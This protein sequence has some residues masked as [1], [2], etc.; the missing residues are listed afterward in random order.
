MKLMRYRSKGKSGP[1]K[2]GLVLGERVLEV[3]RALGQV[4]RADLAASLHEAGGDLEAFI[5]LE[6]G[7]CPL[8]DFAAAYLEGQRRVGDDVLEQLSGV[9]IGPPLLHPEKIIGIGL[10]Y[11]SHA[12]ETGAEIPKQPIFFAKYPN[13][14]NAT[15]RPVVKSA[16]TDKLDYEV[17]LAVVIGKKG[18]W[19]PEESALDYVFG[20]MAANDV[21]ARDLQVEDGQWTKGKTLDT[22]FPIGPVLVTKNDIPDPQNLSLKLTLNG[23]VMQSGNTSDMIFSVKRLVSYLS[24]LMTLSPGDIIST[25]TPPGVG[26]ARK[27]PVFLRPGDVM[28]AEVEGIGRLENRIVAEE[29]PEG[30]D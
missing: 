22:F 27:P 15:A 18:K 19:I 13:T 16:L 10:N 6:E 7:H 5:R 3:G 28:I 4:G 2:L 23:E 1:W 12:A 29:V 17:E 25:G 8:E 26:S 20:Y 24:G 11:A 14:I 30:R 21:S 9:E